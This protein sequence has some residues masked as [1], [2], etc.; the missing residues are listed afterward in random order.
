MVT[1]GTPFLGNYIY[2]YAH[3]YR[4]FLKWWYPQIIQF[5]RMF[6]FE[7]SIL[8]YLHL[9]KPTYMTSQTQSDGETFAGACHFKQGFAAAAIGEYTR[10]CHSSLAKL[11]YNSNNG[12]MVHT[13]IYI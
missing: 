5:S 13:H 10:W 2:I 8:G 3:M 7:P 1:W 12:F 11:V 6:H 4:D 9:W